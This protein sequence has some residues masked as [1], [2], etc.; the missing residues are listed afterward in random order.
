MPGII[1]GVTY[2]DMNLRGICTV[3]FVSPLQDLV[4]PR[5]KGNGGYSPNSFGVGGGAGFHLRD[6]S[7][8]RLR[9][10][11]VRSEPL[12]GCRVRTIGGLGRG[13]GLMRVSSCQ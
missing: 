8:N 7:R 10:M 5:K 6:I 9:F 11:V 4:C 13:L 12:R 1:S 3:T 2:F